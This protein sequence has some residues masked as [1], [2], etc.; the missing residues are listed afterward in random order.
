MANFWNDT[1]K[2]KGKYELK[3]ALAVQGFTFV[4]IYV[5]IPVFIPAFD[6]KEFVVFSLLAF[7]GTCIG[8]ALQEKIKIDN[9]TN[10]EEQL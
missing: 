4:I 9:L 2:P 5:F 8:V 3:R 6:V 7:S 1:L 10:K